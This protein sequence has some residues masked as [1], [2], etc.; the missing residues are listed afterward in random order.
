MIEI[1]RK[2]RVINQNLG[3]LGDNIGALALNKG[4]NRK[5]SQKC[6]KI[7]KER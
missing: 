4:F 3:V 6:A 5:E 7:A 1:N 2:N